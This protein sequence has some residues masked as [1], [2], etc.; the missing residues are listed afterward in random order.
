M[1]ATDQNGKPV[2][3][4]VAP[5]RHTVTGET[6]WAA[7]LYMGFDPAHSIRRAVFATKAAADDA[8]ICDYGDSH[9]FR[10]HVAPD[11]LWVENSSS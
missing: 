7:T 5:V 2:V 10:G 9:A 8:Y 11:S 6:G 1:H 4:N 3:R